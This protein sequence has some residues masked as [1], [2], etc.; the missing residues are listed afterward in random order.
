M[1]PLIS[2]GGDIRE[3]PNYSFAGQSGN[4]KRVAAV[5]ARDQKI[6]S[7]CLR[8]LQLSPDKRNK[9]PSAAKEIN[10]QLLQAEVQKSL[11]S[12]KIT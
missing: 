8:V 4:E 10:V 2:C 5:G 11:K 3:P 12:C 1:Q 9:I 7:D 6:P